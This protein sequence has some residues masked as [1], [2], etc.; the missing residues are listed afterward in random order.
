MFVSLEASELADG[1]SLPS[2]F[3]TPNALSTTGG[4]NTSS[5]SPSILHGG[6]S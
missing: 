2:R 4:G 1:G 5:S 6:H 3:A